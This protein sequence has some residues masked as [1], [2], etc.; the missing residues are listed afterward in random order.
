MYVFISLFQTPEKRYS[1][2]DTTLDNS[3]EYVNTQDQQ[4]TAT[5][6]PTDS[7]LDLQFQDFELEDFLSIPDHSLD[8]VSEF[9]LKPESDIM[10][11]EIEDDDLLT[12]TD[13][14]LSVNTD[15][16]LTSEED[17]LDSK[18]LYDGASVTTG[19][20][21]LLLALF[22]SKHNI[23]GDGIQQLLNII[24]LALPVVHN[25][26]LSLCTFKTF[27]KN[28]RNPLIKHY[29]CPS[30]FG[31][32]E[33]ATDR[34]CENS[35]CNKQLDDNHPYFLEVPLIDQIRSKFC[36]SG[37]FDN[38][39]SR[40]SRRLGEVYE[41][42]YDGSIYQKLFVND[43][44][45]SQQE[46]I[47]FI[48]N[49]DGAPVFK[50]SNTS[51]WPLY[52]I[53]NELPYKQRM[54]R[55]NMILAGLWFGKDKPAMSTFLKPFLESMKHFDEGV[56]MTSPERGTFTCKAYL[57]AG[58]ADLPA[59]C[60]LCH[61]VQYNG[62][63]GCWKCLQKGRTAKVG[64]GHTHIFQ[65]VNENPKGP[66]RT[67]EGVIKDSK[68]IVT[69]KK[70]GQKQS[71]VNGVKGPSWLLLFPKFCIVDGIAIDY[72]HGVLLGV[73][74][75]LIRLWFSKD[76]VSKP[77]S[78]YQSVCK[79]DKLLQSIRPT[80]EITRLPRSIEN[81]LRYWK[82]SEFRS[83]LLFYGAPI[84][85]TILDT[86]RFQHY[87]KLVQAMFL[88]LKFGS[89][90]SDIDKAENL[91]TYFC[92]N[93]SELYDECYMTLNLH[94]LMHLADNVRNLGPLY[95]HSCFSFEDKNGF[96]LK[97]IRVTQNIDT[98]ILTG[99]LLFRNYLS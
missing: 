28:L 98:Q 15:E 33:N 51:I 65:F 45:L 89:S 23:T 39:K 77:F 11:N 64:K 83:F 36:Q 46:N 84:L 7:K 58:T 37:F 40:F 80:S 44:P 42:I 88:L 69:I 17:D 4:T 55:E 54:N 2:L 50:S 79:V 90:K 8:D 66:L 31:H 21:M 14:F 52:L 96:V 92:K 85:K 91:L 43:G 19:A 73:Q 63:Y 78:F 86:A 59:R 6:L 16:S 34:F 95:T 18:P 57:L 27:F 26:S 74:K 97:T 22:T 38:L 60:L 30:C 71:N 48:F 13:N 61:S 70:Q 67:K 72:M 24:S 87:L 75:L 10:N 56:K 49:T 62:A 53:I 3:N 47:S 81:D 1:I 68:E 25:L 82:A 76:F 35:H 32:L 41:D 93:F 99:Y 9:T 5:C 29:Y 94:Q 12:F 20:F